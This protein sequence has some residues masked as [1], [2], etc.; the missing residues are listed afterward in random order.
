MPILKSETD[1]YPATLLDDMA[2]ADSERKWWAVYTKSR[3]EKAIARQLEGMDVPFYL[4]LVSQTRIIGER[5]VKSLLPLF[6]SY[7]FVFGN[8]LERVQTLSTQ[9]VTQMLPSPNNAV[10]TQDL[11]NIRTMIAAGI[12]MTIE[13][14]LEPGRRVRIKKGALLGMEGVVVMRRG[15]ERLLVAVQFLQQGVS[16]EINDFQVEPL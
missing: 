11:A 16:I 12:P 3:Q 4:P 5:K 14:R 1:L 8:D 13:S 6:P 2:T 7:L 9:R 15:S 10:M